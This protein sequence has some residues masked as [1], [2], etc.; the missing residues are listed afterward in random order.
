MRLTRCLAIF[1]L[2]LPEMVCAS[3]QEAGIAGTAAPAPQKTGDAATTDESAARRAALER[4]VI[5]KWE[6]LIRRD[7]ASAY[8]FTSPAYRKAF[9]LDVFKRG[10]GNARVAWRRIE[11]VSVDFKGDD[12]ATVSIK[13]H[14]VYHDPQTQ[15]SLDMAT[16]D[17]ES[18]VYAD[19]Q[20]WYLVKG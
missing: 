3:D 16:H 5:A 4:R 13:I 17:Q 12:A 11:V 2:L 20:W 14:I 19:G 18:W 15:K 10:F 1:L 8:E 9:S 6:A 7:F